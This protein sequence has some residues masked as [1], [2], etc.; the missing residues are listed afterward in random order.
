MAMLGQRSAYEIIIQQRGP[1]TSLTAEGAIQRQVWQQSMSSWKAFSDMLL[2]CIKEL[3][4]AESNATKPV[5]VMAAYEAMMSG[6]KGEGQDGDEVP[7]HLKQL[8]LDVM[9]IEDTDEPEEE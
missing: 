4:P 1:S 9:E 7:E 6:D 5:D 8:L 2:R 3:R